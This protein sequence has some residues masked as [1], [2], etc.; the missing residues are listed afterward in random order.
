MPKSQPK[1]HISSDTTG[2]VV[3]VLFSIRSLRFSPAAILIILFRLSISYQKPFVFYVSVF[4]SKIFTL[5]LN[6]WEK[7]G[8][9]YAISMVKRHFRIFIGENIFFQ[10]SLVIFNHSCFRTMLIL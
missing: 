7:L 6:S 9:T 2:Q 10:F 8:L 4:C 3:T 5:E 1:T